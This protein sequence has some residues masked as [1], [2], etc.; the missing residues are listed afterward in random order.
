MV[1]LHIYMKLFSAFYPC[2]LS[3]TV[4]G[5]CMQFENSKS[6]SHENSS[7]TD[8]KWYQAAIWLKTP[9]CLSCWSPQ[10][11]SLSVCALSFPTEL[12]LSDRFSLRVNENL[13]TSAV[14]FFTSS[15]SILS[16][17]PLLNLSCWSKTAEDSVVF[18]ITP[19]DRKFLLVSTHPCLSL[20]LGLLHKSSSWGQMEITA[21]FLL[22]WS[23]LTYQPFHSRD[24]LRSSLVQQM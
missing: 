15:Q 7:Q 16:A 23:D 13:L 21:P 5:C 6:R 1:T 10:F 2:P 8:W 4:S 14:G 22:R 20:K 9:F 24:F 19:H 11:E 18:P 12:R 3:I 17:T